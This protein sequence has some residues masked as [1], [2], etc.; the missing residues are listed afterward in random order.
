[1]QNQSAGKSMRVIIVEDEAPARLKLKMQL[2]EL[3]GVSLIAECANPVQAIE[4]INQLKPDLVFVDI[5]LGELSGFDVLEAI[6]QPCHVIFTTA[7][8]QY[9]VKAFESKAIDYL[10]KPFD[11]NRLRQAL[12]RVV[13]P[14]TPGSGDSDTQL[15]AKVGDKMHVLQTADIYFVSAAQGM[16]LAQCSERD[17]HLDVTLETLSQQLPSSFLRVHRNCIVNTKLISQI[18][19]WHNGAF[20]LRFKQLT[21]T[22]TT[23]RSGT[24][25][26]KKHFK[27]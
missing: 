7:Y 1:M 14:H 3:E 6:N 12:S 24:L 4:Q 5:E 25:A 21:A 18:E 27:I 19:K 13:I 15:I 11:L 23:S 17:Y 16:A 26:I 2:Q 22:V 10:L 8:S 9:A 20:L